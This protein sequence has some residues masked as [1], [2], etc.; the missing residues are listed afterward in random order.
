MS[1]PKAKAPQHNSL[2]STPAKASPSVNLPP[3]VLFG[4]ALESPTSRATERGKE[5]SRY[6]LCNHLCKVM[7]ADIPRAQSSPYIGD[8]TGHTESAPPYLSMDYI[9]L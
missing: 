5:C 4:K 3:R 1:Q 8:Y 9:T 7:D 6:D 2:P